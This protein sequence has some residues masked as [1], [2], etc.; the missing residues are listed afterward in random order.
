MDCEKDVKEKRMNTHELKKH[1]PNASKSFLNANA[2][3]FVAALSSEVTESNGQ[4]ALER[5]VRRKKTSRRSVG[6]S[7]GPLLRVGIIALCNRVHDLD[8]LIASYKGLRDR[9]SEEFGLDDADNQVQ[10]AYSQVQ[11]PGE[12]GTIVILQ[13]A[14]F[15]EQQKLGASQ[16]SR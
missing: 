7:T 14:R 8:N 13:T 3:N 12:E 9:I 10:W 1:F 11:W 16:I 6:R 5:F 4:P 15:K 2:A